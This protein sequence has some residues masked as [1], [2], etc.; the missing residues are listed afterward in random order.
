MARSVYRTAAPNRSTLSP[1][2][3]DRATTRHLAMIEVSLDALKKSAKT[4]GGT[5]N[6]AYLAAIAGG[7]RTYHERHGAAVDSLRALMPINLRGREGRRLRQ[8]DHPAAA[9]RAR[10]GDRPGRPDARAAPRGPGG[11][12]G[13]VAFGDRGDR[14]GAQHAAG[15]VRGRDTQARRLRGEQRAG[16]SDAGLPRGQQG[17]R[18]VRVRADHR[19]LRQHHADVLRR[20]LRHRRQHR[21]RRGAGPGRPAGLPA[22]EL[23]RDHRPRR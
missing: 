21:H 2:M 11:A 5:V 23:R 8:P 14:G 1:V 3:R 17:H 15:R 16:R 4:V 19:G 22:G 18:H 12:R 7:L 9:D 6:D 20:H 13:A 10:R